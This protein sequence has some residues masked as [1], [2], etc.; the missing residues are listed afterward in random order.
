M[1]FVNGHTTHYECPICGL[2][3]EDHWTGIPLYTIYKHGDNLVMVNGYPIS[4][5]NNGKT[6]EKHEVKKV[7][8]PNIICGSLGYY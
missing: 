5:P 6:L 3:I 2:E 8:S 4:C 1:A 7:T